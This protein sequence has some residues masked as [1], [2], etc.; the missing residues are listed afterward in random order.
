MKEILQWSALQTSQAIKSRD[1]KAEEV[2]AAHLTQIEAVNPKI[3]AITETFADE[4]I[5]Q[6]KAIDNAKIPENASDLFGV[7][8]TVKI[9]TDFKGSCSSNGIPAFNKQEATQTSPVLQFMQDDGAI[10]IG[11]TNVPELSMRWF[12]S[13]PIYGVTKNPWNANLT[14]GGSSGGAS[15]AVASGIGV[16]AHGS[17]LGG[18]LRYPAYCCGVATIKP[19]VGRVPLYVASLPE[20]RPPMTQS[21]SVHG[22]IARCI[23]DVR[24]ALQS[25]SKFSATDPAWRDALTSG[26]ARNKPLKIG[27]ARTPFNNKIDAEIERGMDIAI[28]GLQQAG[29]I[30][31]EITP[32]QMIRAGEIWMQL[33]FSETNIFLK[34]NQHKVLTPEMSN[35]I[36]L[37]QQAA[38]ADTITLETVMYAMRDRVAIQRDWSRMFANIDMLLLPTSGALPFENDADFKNPQSVS[39]ILQQQRYLTAINVLGL[40]SVALPTHIA[41]TG[42]EK[43][44]VGVQLVGAMFD[45]WFCLDVAQMLEQQIGKFSLPQQ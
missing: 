37:Y 28:N 29:C 40:P 31:E 7:P 25:M 13:N 41:E 39:T 20:E 15:A 36:K 9:N 45:D 27:F 6:A 5:T 30:V 12:S 14:P 19:S 22:P 32:P 16:I 24:V 17:D 10:V 33:L 1:I 2:I 26:N 42:A 21:M 4:S 11:R 34:E 23:S 3:N 38:D 8:V 43:T 18:S 35:L 44:P